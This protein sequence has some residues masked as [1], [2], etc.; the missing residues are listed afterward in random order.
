M[1]PKPEFLSPE[2]TSDF[3]EGGGEEEGWED[4]GEE[5]ETD[6]GTEF[7]ED[8]E[9]ILIERLEQEFRVRFD[10]YHQFVTNER[11][12]L[13]VLGP[14]RFNLALRPKM[15]LQ[16]I[17]SCFSWLKQLHPDQEPLF[18]KILNL[19]AITVPQSGVANPFGRCAH[20]LHPP[21]VHCILEHFCKR[22]EDISNKKT[23]V[24]EE[25]EFWG[26]LIEWM[27]KTVRKEPSAGVSEQL[28]VPHSS[29]HLQFTQEQEPQQTYDRHE[30][31]QRRHCQ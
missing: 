4:V 14:W 1:S 3:E 13:A 19:Y 8:G 28:P 24:Q 6:E 10:A 22:S 31:I 17:E 29:Q 7:E 25:I 21:H 18:R 15:P 5:R 27:S 16:D 2:L 11:E 23:T 9:D 20:I 30:R 26:R 12:C